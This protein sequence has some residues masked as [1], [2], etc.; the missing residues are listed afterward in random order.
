MSYSVF[1]SGF[2]VK[3]VALTKGKMRRFSVCMYR[4]S[5][6]TQL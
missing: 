2:D 6:V 1:K 5:V 4:T 3:A